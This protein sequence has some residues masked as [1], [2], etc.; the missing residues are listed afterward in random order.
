MIQRYLLQ[1]TLHTHNGSLQKIKSSLAEFGEHIE[2]ATVTDDLVKGND[3][4][5]SMCTEDPTLIFDVCSQFGRITSVKVNE[6]A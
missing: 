4:K 3:F 5:V 2:V 1:F 6:E